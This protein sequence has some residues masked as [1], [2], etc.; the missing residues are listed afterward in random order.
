MATGANLLLRVKAKLMARLKKMENEGG[1]FVSVQFNLKTRMLVF[2]L[3]PIILSL[4]LIGFVSYHYATEAMNYQITRTLTF[5]TAKHAG[6]VEAW[7][8]GKEAL[9][10]YLSD[11]LSTGVVSESDTI[12]IIQKSKQS[13]K[14]LANIS[15][16]YP[17]KKIIDALNTKW[18][19]NFDPTSRDWYKKAVDSQGVV[20]SEVFQ[21]A[22]THKS[23]FSIA[24][25]IR[26]NGAV[27]SVVNAP[28]ELDKLQAIMKEVK[29]GKTG[30]G[31]VLDAKGN[32]LYHP[33]LKITDNIFT[34]QNGAFKESALAYLSGKP[35]FQEYEF[36]GVAKFYSSVPIG[37]TGW[38]L[39]IGVPKAELFED[40]AHFNKINI[41]ISIAVL[42]ALVLIILYVANSVV[43][44]VRHIGLV[45]EKVADGDL[46]HNLE[47]GS[48]RNDEL[49]SLANSFTNM[50]INLRS[51]I[52]QVSASTDQV[53]ASS[54]E[55]TA[56]A[57]QSAQAA[58]QVA[59]AITE[60]ANGSGEQLA[61]ANDT[62]A[63]VQQMSAS[64]QQTAVNTNEVAGQ[65]AKAAEKANEGNAAVE[66][67]V[68]QMTRLE[69]TV[70][71]SAN[72][73][74]EL[75]ERSKEIGKIVDTI[76]GIAG[77][78]NL[79][80]LN[81]AI[82]AAR[83]GEQGRGFAVVAEEVR[84]LAEQ[85]QEAT[86]QIADLIGQIQGDTDRAVAAMNNGTRE[87]KL[88][89]EVVNASG[90]AFREIVVLVNQV[91]GQV[92]E[93][94]SAMEHM[95]VGS[96]QIVGSVQRIDGL[97]KKAAGEAQTV[98]AATE[99][100]SASMEEIAS[101]SQALAKLAEDLQTA[102]RRFRI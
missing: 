80:A 79:L 83:A 87:A 50:I 46:S 18:A 101:S 19:S 61:A 39:V 37:N 20:Y 102:V 43:R 13:H 84:K 66:K 42:L 35:A 45:A 25:A 28:L 32:Y 64:I 30:Y 90:Q 85:S 71:T 33:T 57:E 54:E 3:I 75:G 63:V 8:A 16:G 22:S 1:V 74:A 9:V 36:G 59:I 65:S 100:Q 89:A 86:K 62:A 14:D 31:F 91:S 97:S 96:R 21:I 5:M 81:A 93:I 4:S 76:S 2:L 70:N 82:E 10:E 23:G 51:L 53:A 88:G 11:T 52:K 41:G 60:I 68:T 72:I 78:T 34:L 40:I 26:N 12:Q 27:T 24:K 6:E 49:G 98:S 29:S 7:L 38:V 17:N 99:E 94:S 69:Q 47:T 58:N 48:F 77:Q 95:A 44:P 67:A 56:S 73:V 92:K 55:L 15:I